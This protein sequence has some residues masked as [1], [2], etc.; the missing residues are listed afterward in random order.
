M[1]MKSSGT[2]SWNH[3]AES[4]NVCSMQLFP[5]S[6][7]HLRKRWV[8]PGQGL[9]I[10]Q[11]ISMAFIRPRLRSVR[12]WRKGGKAFLYKNNQLIS[13]FLQTLQRFGIATVK[14]DI[15]KKECYVQPTTI[16]Q[17]RPGLVHIGHPLRAREHHP[18]LQPA[19]PQRRGDEC[20]THPSLAG[21]YPGG[22]YRLPPRRLC[23]RQFTSLERHPQCPP[24][25]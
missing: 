9:I 6:R 17:P 24:R 13:K 25:P 15:C 2:K 3:F 14:D 7:R 23:A 4:P 10:F 1:W 21:G 19:V 8:P 16:L 5:G 20:R 18:L 22:R 12:G 11:G